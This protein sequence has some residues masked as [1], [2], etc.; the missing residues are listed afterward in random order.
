MTNKLRTTNGCFG[1]GKNVLFDTDK[2]KYRSCIGNYRDPSY[3]DLY[4]LYDV[5]KK[6]INP[7]GGSII[8]TP[9]KFVEICNLLDNLTIAKQL[10]MARKASKN[11]K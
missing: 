8:D 4:A 3:G 10:E 2:I 9:N 6:G 7:F 11:G 1:V 5:Y